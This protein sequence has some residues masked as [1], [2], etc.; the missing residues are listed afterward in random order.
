MT[1]KIKELIS[2]STDD[3]LGVKVVDNKRLVALV[4]KECLDI[5]E[6]R[7]DQAID[8]DWK[9]DEAMSC[10]SMHIEEY[11]GLDDDQR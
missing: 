5:I 4:V 9:V 11:F 1:D 10:A 8:M 2:A 3:I 6:E 7:K